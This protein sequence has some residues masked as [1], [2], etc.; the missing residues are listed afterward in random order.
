MNCCPSFVNVAQGCT[1]IF[2]HDLKGMEGFENKEEISKLYPE[3]LIK[4]DIAVFEFEVRVINKGK[5]L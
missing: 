1:V 3:E 2:R 4:D 5:L